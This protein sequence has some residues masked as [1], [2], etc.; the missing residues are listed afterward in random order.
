MAR[1][2]GLENAELW[3]GPIT[4]SWARPGYP[5]DAESTLFEADLPRDG[6]RVIRELRVPERVLEEAGDGRV[7]IV[8]R[9]VEGG[10]YEGVEL[11][12]PEGGWTRVG[13]FPRAADVFGDG[14]LWVVDA[15][16][17]CVGHVMGLVRVKIGGEGEGEDDWVLL[18][19]DCFHHVD[20]LREP[21]KMARKPYAEEGMH[22]DP[23]VAMESI[24]RTRRMAV[25]RNVWVVQAHDPSVARA[26]GVEDHE[27]DGGVKGLVRLDDWREKGWKGKQGKF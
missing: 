17:H 4:T 27:K 13:S 23:V 11:W 25:E 1:S 21:E 7:G 16:G 26:L 15:P 19:G 6:S 22:A 5:V 12:E 2:G 18:A 20:L 24:W 3:L 10:R 9:A 14:S 8:Q